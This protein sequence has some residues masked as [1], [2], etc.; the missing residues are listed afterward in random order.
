MARW[1]VLGAFLWVN[2]GASVPALVAPWALGGA[3]VDTD[4]DHEGVGVTGHG[5]IDEC[6]I[7]LNNG[8]EV[9]VAGGQGVDAIGEKGGA[10]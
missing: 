9:V 1:A 2:E 6:S 10:M 3:M 7:G 5:G 4:L 8:L